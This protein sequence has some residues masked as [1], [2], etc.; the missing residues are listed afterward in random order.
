M[1]KS[2]RYFNVNTLP[3]KMENDI[4]VGSERVNLNEKVETEAAVCCS[5]AIMNGENGPQGAPQSN[6]LEKLAHAGTF[7]S[8]FN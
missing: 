8:P 2:L 5:R 4:K 1:S 7:C 6:Q 3:L